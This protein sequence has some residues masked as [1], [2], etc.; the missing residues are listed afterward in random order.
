MTSEDPVRRAEIVQV[1]Q[2][3]GA[4]PRIFEMANDSIRSNEDDDD[5]PKQH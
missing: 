3:Y 1:L 2:D 5:Q 4:F